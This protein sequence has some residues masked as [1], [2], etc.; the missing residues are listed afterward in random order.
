MTGWRARLLDRFPA[1]QGELVLVSDPDGLVTDEGVQQVLSERGYD[2]LPFEDPVAFRLRYEAAWRTPGIQRRSLVVV[3]SSGGV[4]EL[5]WDLV[6]IG[7]QESLG[8]GDLYPTLDPSVL[9]LV[10]TSLLD[11]VEGGTLP[12]R[13]EGLDIT[14][15][16]VLRRVYGIDPSELDR[17][18]AVLAALF[19]LHQ[20]GAPLPAE[21]AGD[22]APPVLARAA[23]AWPL[24]KLLAERS[25][26]V[27]WVSDHW[28]AYVR[29]KLVP[30]APV[31]G[32]PPMEW[33]EDLPDLPFEYMD[34]RSLLDTWFLDGVL[35]QVDVPSGLRPVQGA[36]WIEVGLR[37]DPK[38]DAAKRFRTLLNRVEIPAPDAGEAA[39]RRVAWELSE[40]SILRW[41]CGLPDED[42]DEARYTKLRADADDALIA[43]SLQ[44]YGRLAS[45]PHH[46]APVMVHHVPRFMADRL[47]HGR[48]LALLVMDGLALDQ[49]IALRDAMPPLGRVDHD[50]RATFAWVPTL[51][52]VSRQTIFRGEPP[53]S[54]PTSIKT[55]SREETWWKQ[56]W[57]ARG[58]RSVGY[59]AS[60]KLLS[61]ERLDDL[62]GPNG[63]RVL[64]LV[65]NLVDDFI[66]HWDMAR[67]AAFG[68]LADSA[69]KPLAELL[70]RLLDAGY[71][72]FLTADHGNEYATGVGSPG[73]GV[74]PTIRGERARAY[75]TDALRQDALS[76]VPGAICWPGPGLPPDFHVVLAPRGRSFGADRKRGITHGGISVA[77][78]FVPFVHIRRTT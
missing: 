73:E 38:E 54:F 31:A 75:A 4:A 13:R 14:R 24:A 22:V 39:W 76:R 3:R 29:K 11:R 58:V 68:V 18:E 43:W 60:Q 67:G 42:P 9:R 77:E 20:A 34:V 37:R 55:T 28:R 6:S 50:E 41:R 65:W 53:Y 78:L 5:P 12:R 35:P 23:V 16:L 64:G 25:A 33:G 47:D 52:S 61:D 48:R 15:T 49:W 32:E 71:E 1:G 44:G 57:D 69:A 56:F 74:L 10:P 8:L 21:F 72:V 46:P 36:E 30:D 63:P 27:R 40:L 45:L 51:T 19:R 2:V 7:R 70:N 17:P 62:V 66:H 59:L 26:F